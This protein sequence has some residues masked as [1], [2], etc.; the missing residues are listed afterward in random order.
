MISQYGA[1]PSLIETLRTDESG[2][3]DDRSLERRVRIFLAGQHAH[4]GPNDPERV[5]VRA[6][7]GQV[8]L[9]GFVRG[10]A[11]RWALELAAR[12]VAGVRAVK[13]QLGVTTAPPRRPQ[14]N[15]FA[16]RPRL[17]RTISLRAGLIRLEQLTRTSIKAI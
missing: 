11:R 4:R 14:S 12:R 5:E 9:F 7:R 2:L 17:G 15:Q 1:D 10:A 13:N 6:L 8:T 3:F 16:R